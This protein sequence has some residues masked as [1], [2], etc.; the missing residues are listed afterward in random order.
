MLQLLKKTNQNMSY[1][2]R[3]TFMKKYRI[4]FKRYCLYTCGMWVSGAVLEGGPL[5]CI[6]VVKPGSCLLIDFIASASQRINYG[7]RIQPPP[8][9]PAQTAPLCRRK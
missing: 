4:T 9:P 2:A 1:N 6:F 5:G 3:L 7:Q 8:S